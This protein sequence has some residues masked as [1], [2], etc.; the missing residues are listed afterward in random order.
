MF[1]IYGSHFKEKKVLFL[2]EA[3]PSFLIRE[4]GRLG[5]LKNSDPHACAWE[6]HGADPPGRAA[7]A[8]ARLG[9]NPRQPAQLYQG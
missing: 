3:A 6:N 9:G 1:R 7:K 8:H 2:G 5:E 4:K